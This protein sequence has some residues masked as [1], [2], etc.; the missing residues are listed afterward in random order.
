MFTE[1]D[2]KMDDHIRDQLAEHLWLDFMDFARKQTRSTLDIDYDQLLSQYESEK[3]INNELDTQFSNMLINGN[4]VMSHATDSSTVSVRSTVDYWLVSP[5][6]VL[7][8][9]S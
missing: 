7:M 1:T 4:L 6:Q 3:D 9:R 8:I 5:M 2:G